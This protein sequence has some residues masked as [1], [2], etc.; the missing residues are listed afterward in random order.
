MYPRKENPHN[1]PPPPPPA[2]NPKTKHT[3]YIYATRILKFIEP[4]A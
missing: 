4:F 2:K 1:Y 3:K